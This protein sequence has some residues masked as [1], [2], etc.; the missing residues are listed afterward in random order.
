MVLK[1]RI[2]SRIDQRQYI[3]AEFFVI[4][5]FKLISAETLHT[6]LLPE[7]WLIS[8]KQTKHPIN[9]QNMKHIVLLLILSGSFIRCQSGTTDPVYDDKNSVEFWDL[10]TGS[11]IAYIHIPAADT[12]N[13]IPLIFLHG[14]PGACQVNSFGKEAPAGWYHQLAS[15]NFDVYIY[16]QVGSGLSERLDNPAEYT[17]KRHVQDLENIRIIVGNKPCILVGDS[18]G[19]TLACHY[20]AAYPQHVIKAIFTSPGSIDIREWNDEYSRVPRKWINW[21]MTLSHLKS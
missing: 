15:K 2:D 8:S 3:P 6:K 7:L 10:A 14:G 19:A 13:A 1:Y 18:W 12:M 16:D 4:C 11:H 20:M 21:Q 17:V 5:C 9:I